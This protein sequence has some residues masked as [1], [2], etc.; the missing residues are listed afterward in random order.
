MF[1]LVSRVRQ[2]IAGDVL[3][4]TLEVHIHDAKSDFPHLG[5]VEG[6]K[7]YC[8]RSCLLP[9]IAFVL[10]RRDADSALWFEDLQRAGVGASETY[11]IEPE[12]G[13][14]SLYQAVLSDRRAVAA[15]YEVLRAGGKIDLFCSSKG[16]EV[17]CEDLKV[18][19]LN[20]SLTVDETPIEF[21]RA[22]H[23][24][25]PDR[26]A[27]MV[28]NDKLRSR[29]AAVKGKNT[30]KIYPQHTI[31][32][33][34]QEL[35]EAVRV[36]AMRRNYVVKLDPNAASTEQMHFFRKGVVPDFGEMLASWNPEGGAIVEGFV[37][38]VPA[39]LTFEIS[40]GQAIFLYA[41]LQ[42]LKGI[43][44][45]RVITVEDIEADDRGGHE[46]NFVGSYGQDLGDLKWVEI[47][48]AILFVRPMLRKVIE[49]G[50]VGRINMDLAMLGGGQVKKLEFN[51]RNSHSTYTA[52]VQMAV[53]GRF[54]DGH[55]V[56]YAG[57]VDHVSET[58]TSYAAARAMLERHGLLYRGGAQPGVLLYHAPLLAHGLQ[59]CGIVAIGHTMLEVQA[60]AHR[61]TMLLRN[62]QMSLDLAG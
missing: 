5:K 40:E 20:Y 16:A 7:L 46:G 60:F 33:N 50:Y 3:R 49:S 43:P 23:L 14:D 2:L 22:A 18:S 38:H 11:W 62:S 10:G 30:R 37:P 56:V 12:E 45:G 24:S 39:S 47:E 29:E 44:S 25:N 27:S 19:I 32:R 51:A 1:D 41:S 48:Q 6:I 8:F 36:Y 42:K 61:A 59:K 34:E 52:A 26:R 55:A 28:W 57:N 13:V 4:K 17:F 35:M 54:V 58:I 15:I 53:A 9:G 21:D 31:C